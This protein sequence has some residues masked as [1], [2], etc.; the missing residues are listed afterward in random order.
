M[1]AINLNGC[2]PLWKSIKWRSVQ[3]DAALLQRPKLLAIQLHCRCSIRSWI[4]LIS[5]PLTFVSEPFLMSEKCE[6]NRGTIEGIKLKTYEQG[7]RFLSP[8][9]NVLLPLGLFSE[10]TVDSCVP[11]NLFIYFLCVFV[12][13]SFARCPGVWKSGGSWKV[14]LRSRAGSDRWLDSAVTSALHRVWWGNK[15]DERIIWRK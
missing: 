1:I 13:V 4:D 5:S 15:R 3:C 10:S 9:E 8:L 2:H 7:Y 14:W 12:S 11:P 6:T